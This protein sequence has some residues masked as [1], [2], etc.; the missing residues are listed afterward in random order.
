MNLKSYILRDL[1][2]CSYDEKIVFF[3]LFA[4]YFTLFYISTLWWSIWFI[5]YKERNVDLCF[6]EKY[7]K[8]G[9][10]TFV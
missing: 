10:H 3:L 5:D 4:F 9:L 8:S 6:G 2:I 1:F 7:I